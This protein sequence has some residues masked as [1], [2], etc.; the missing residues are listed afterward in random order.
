MRNSIKET[1]DIRVQNVVHLLAGNP[2]N[3]CIQRIVLTAIGPKSIREPEEILLV[4]R[5]QH[6]DRRSLYDLIFESGDRERS[7]SAIRLRYV[8]A[9][10]RQR[11]IG[12]PLD[13]C[14]QISEVSFKVCFIGPPR[15]PVHTRRGVTLELIKHRPE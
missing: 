5:V 11:P 12:S 2:D 9:A 14:V 4:Y 8:L 3:K 1:P 7:L 6:R 13:P 15:Q 10:A